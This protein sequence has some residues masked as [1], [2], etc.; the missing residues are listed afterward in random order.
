MEN[1]KCSFCGTKLEPGTGILFAKKDGS[2]YNFC[3]SKC[4]NNYKM[5]RLPRRT[6]WTETGRTYM[7]KA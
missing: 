1:K 3:S 6:I 4:R 2:T 7:K 5:G